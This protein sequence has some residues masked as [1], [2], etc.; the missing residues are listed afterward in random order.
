[1]LSYDAC[2]CISFSFN[3]LIVS[4]S[5]MVWRSVCVCVKLLKNASRQIHPW[6]KNFVR[7]VV[8]FFSFNSLLQQCICLFESS[9]FDLL[10]AFRIVPLIRIQFDCISFCTHW[11]VSR[12]SVFFCQ[13]SALMFSLSL[14]SARNSPVCPFQIR[15]LSFL[16][17]QTEKRIYKNNDDYDRKKYNNNSTHFVHF[18]LSADI[19]FSLSFHTF[20]WIYTK[21]FNE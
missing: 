14:S 2:W 17:A 3:R 19:L 11:Q 9:L 15:V 18:L 4:V 12:R 21:C 7:V 13:R 5:V 1:M 16:F 10:F 8:F 6:K 20:L